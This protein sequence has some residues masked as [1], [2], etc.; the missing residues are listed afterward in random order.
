MILMVHYCI[1]YCNVVSG[2]PMMLGVRLCYMMLCSVEDEYIY[3]PTGR[4]FY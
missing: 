3:L 2:E 4:Y 1:L